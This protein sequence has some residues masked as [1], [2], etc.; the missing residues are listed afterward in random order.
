MGLMDN[1]KRTKKCPR[2]KEIKDLDI[3]YHYS[4]HANNKRQTYCK[5]CNNEIDKIKRDKIKANG[6][7]IIRTEKECLD[8][9]VIK[10]ISDFGLRRSA[11][12]WH[13]SY[14]KPC[15]VKRVGGYYK[16]GRDTMV[17]P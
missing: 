8:C 17:L 1:Q 11:P 14:C 7:T 5:V 3:D 4:T 13:L 15:W 16:K 9:H 10:N 12:D 2:C 6:P